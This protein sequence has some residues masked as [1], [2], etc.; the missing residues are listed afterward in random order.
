[1]V[2]LAHHGG[3]HVQPAPVRHADD[4]F[5][6]AQRAPALDDLLQRRDH[7]LAAV[8][9]E[10]LGAR[11]ALVQEA[12]E[13]LGLDQLLQDR[14]LAL[15]RETDL[16]AASLDPLLDPGLLL[17]IGDVHV[18]HSDVPAVGAAQD[19]EDLAQG[20]G[21][22]PQHVIEEDR[23][24][25]VLFREAVGGRVELGVLDPRVQPQGVEVGLKVAADPIGPDQHDRPHRIQG[26]GAD[27]VGAR[28]RLLLRDDL[29]ELGLDRRPQPV[30]GG[31]PLGT[32]G[33]GGR[34]LPLGIGHRLA[35]RLGAVPELLEEGAP[36]GADRLRRFS[37]LGVEILYEG[38]VAAIEERS[39]RQDL[40]DPSRIVRHVRSLAVR[41]L[42][43]GTAV[44][45]IVSRPPA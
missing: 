28:A 35:R 37:P 5:I 39:L 44:R 40:I 1:M 10:A 32:R 41:Q 25:E 26:G 12:L 21:L 8:Q 9:A 6:D 18:L 42:R 20:R 38:G 24:V 17:G 43:P 16:L 31:Q 22:Q 27:L 14:D 4:D 13:A 15:G 29:G 19:V 3:Q 2:G 34:P 11:E 36:R 33:R 23:P 30:D 45:Y 7:G